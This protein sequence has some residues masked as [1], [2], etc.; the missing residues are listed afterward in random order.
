MATPSIKN[1]LDR[2]DIYRKQVLSSPYANGLDIEEVAEYLSKLNLQR[3]AS[4]K[5]SQPKLLPYVQPRGGYPTFQAQKILSEALYQAGADFIPLTIDSNTRHNAYSRAGVLLERSEEEGKNYLN[6]YPLINHGYYLSRE[7]FRNIDAPISLRH[8]T[9]D[10]RLLVEMALASGITEIEGGGIVYTMPYSEDFPIDLSLLYWQY[11]NRICAVYSTT[12]R[13]IHRESFG[14]MTATMVPPVITVVVELIELLLAAEQ[15]IKSFTVGYGQ[16]G[17]ISQDVATGNALRT[18]SRKYLD[19]FG[20][21]DVKVALVYHQWMGAFPQDRNLALGLIS[22]SALIAKLIHAD[23]IVIKTQDEAFGIPTVQSNCDAVKLVK[24]I[25]NTTMFDGHYDSSMVLEEIDLITQEADYLLDA[26]FNISGE[27]FW[28]SVFQ[29]I[30]QGYI[31][32]PFAPHRKNANHLITQRD[33]DWG[34]RILNPGKVPI[35]K[36]LLLRE[37][38]KL[39]S[40]Q[41][42]N[43]SMTTKLIQD[44]NIML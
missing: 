21:N 19:L 9:P 26:I 16:T 12:E 42:I 29:A 2:I 40:K 43:T 17:S 38:M 37:Q 31:D 13:P 32:I 5:L 20:F 18:L 44:I 3:F 7:L 8:G 22:T 11:V 28:E 10:A 41:T 24:Y 27:V 34:I 14:P 36:D 1:Q 15:G 33:P 6:G 30:I 39:S 25:L 35:S 4:F 23:K